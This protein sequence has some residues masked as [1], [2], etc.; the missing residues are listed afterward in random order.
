MPIDWMER[1]GKNRC[2]RGIAILHTLYRPTIWC[3][4]TSRQ[5]LELRLSCFAKD[6]G[7]KELCAMTEYRRAFS[8]RVPA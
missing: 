6:R 4:I 3:G 5:S 8:N 1:I 2:R 7:I